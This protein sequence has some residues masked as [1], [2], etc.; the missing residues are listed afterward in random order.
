VLLSEGRRGV[1]ILHM[2][3]P[4]ALRRDER[5]AAA[6]AEVLL[7]IRISCIQWVVLCSAWDKQVRCT[8]LTGYGEDRRTIIAARVVAQTTMVP[9]I[10]RVGVAREWAEAIGLGRVGDESNGSCLR[11]SLPLREARSY[12]VLPVNIRLEPI[13]ITWGCQLIARPCVTSNP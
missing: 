7:V 13:S 11:C 12:D 1:V 4:R 8:G 5:A 9:L 2:T 6:T 3:R 10:I